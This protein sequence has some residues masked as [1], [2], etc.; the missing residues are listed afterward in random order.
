MPLYT[1]VRALSVIVFLLYFLQ[2]IEF[3][4]LLHIY[5]NQQCLK[6]NMKIC[7]SRKIIGKQMVYQPSFSICF[8]VLFISRVFYIIWSLVLNQKRSW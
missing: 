1:H 2:I 8:I 5:F 6:Y 7:I 4:Y 3:V